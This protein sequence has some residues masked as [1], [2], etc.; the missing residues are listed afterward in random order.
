[1]RKVIALLFFVLFVCGCEE[2]GICDT[3]VG[4]LKGVWK[5]TI[6]ETE[7]YVN[8]DGEKEDIY[9]DIDAITVT[10]SKNGEIMIESNGEFYSMC[11]ASDENICSLSVE[12][13]EEGENKNETE[14]WRSDRKIRLDRY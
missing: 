14:V 10:I 5:L 6:T 13:D 2:P 12:C 7:Y 1:M 11:S 4:D 9:E 3:Y 8:S